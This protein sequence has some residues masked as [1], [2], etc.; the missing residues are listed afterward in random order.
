[1]SVEADEP[2]IDPRLLEML[3]CPVTRGPLTYDRAR[4]ELVSEKARLAYPIRDG[5]PVMLAE[6]ARPLDP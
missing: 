2:G 4:Q 1:M 3:V 5:I 6:E